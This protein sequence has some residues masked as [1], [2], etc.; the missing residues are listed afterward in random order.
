MAFD[1]KREYMEF[2]RNAEE[3][4]PCGNGGIEDLDKSPIL[5]R[6]SIGGYCIN[7]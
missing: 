4:N 1:Y 5:Q 7:Q 3:Y 6:K 2:Y